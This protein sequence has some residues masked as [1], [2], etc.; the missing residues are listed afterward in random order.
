MD[1][2]TYPMAGRELARHQESFVERL[3]WDSRDRLAI[4][5]DVDT[6]FLETLADL[7]R[8][9]NSGSE[10]D[11]QQV[12]ALLRKLLLDGRPLMDAANRSRQMRIRFLVKD[13]S[14]SQD[15]IL[16]T[17]P[18]FYALQDGFDPATS[19]VASVRVADVGRD[20]LLERGLVFMDGVWFSV[21]D[22]IAYVSHVEGGVHRGPPK[23]DK[24]R[25]L[26][27]TSI[28][29]GGYDSP[30]VRSL[31]AVARVV[32]RGLEPLETRIRSDRAPAPS[33]HD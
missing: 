2:V 10:Y 8:R 3:V 33:R 32:A 16:S 26:A 31:L 30:V 18:A 5:M 6:L 28:R 7:R 20:G 24:Q 13:G 11:V 15:L 1:R 14:P 25:A 23:G 22:I 19:L 12:A 4:G 9:S 29:I 17:G 27:A 21:A